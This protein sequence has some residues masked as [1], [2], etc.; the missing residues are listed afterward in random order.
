MGRGEPSPFQ[1]TADEREER[2]GGARDLVE[3]CGVL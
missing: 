1:K 2:S 3:E